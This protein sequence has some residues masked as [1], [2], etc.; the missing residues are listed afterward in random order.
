MK[1][2]KCLK[3]FFSDPLFFG[4]WMIRLA[5]AVLFIVA[6]VNKFKFGYAGFVSNIIEADGEV[7]KYIPDFLL[8]FYAYSLPVVELAAGIFLLVDRTTKVGYYLLSY[9]YLTFIFGRAFDGNI[10]VVGQEYLPAIL[11]IVIGNYLHDKT[12]K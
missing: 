7:T 10:P 6:A 8:Y 9:V 2:K 3:K 5:F 12:T 4:S 1:F 11:L